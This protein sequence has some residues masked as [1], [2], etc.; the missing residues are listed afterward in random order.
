MCNPDFF[1][2]LACEKLTGSLRQPRRVALGRGQAHPGRAFGSTQHGR[3]KEKD[4]TRSGAFVAHS[5]C[6]MVMTNDEESLDYPYYFW[7]HALVFVDHV[8]S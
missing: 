2:D 1:R 3:R 4:R 6:S 7:H 8:M 5:Y